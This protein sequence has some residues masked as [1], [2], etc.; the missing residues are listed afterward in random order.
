MVWNR[1]KAKKRLLSDSWKEPYNT[2]LITSNETHWDSKYFGVQFV[3]V[4]ALNIF[5]GFC[6]NGN[7]LRLGF[8]CHKILKQKR[9]NVVH[10]YCTTWGYSFLFRK[11]PI[12]AFFQKL[13]ITYKY[14]KACIWDYQNPV[15]GLKS[16]TAGL[17]FSLPAVSQT[18]KP[19]LD[20]NWVNR[21]FREDQRGCN[22][23]TNKRACFVWKWQWY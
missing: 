10:N 14:I 5:L 1:L 12:D 9:R 13:Q 16:V 18:T 4:F 6:K 2:I 22:S 3:S 21:K 11:G 19:I 7:P 23:G 20:A 8:E 17:Y 15:S